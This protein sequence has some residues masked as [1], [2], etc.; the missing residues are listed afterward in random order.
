MD[1][2]ITAAKAYTATK[3]A[4]VTSTAASSNDSSSS[5][6]GDASTTATSSTAAAAGTATSQPSDELLYFD[7]D[8]PAAEVDKLR[9]FL[10]DITLH[11]CDIASVAVPHEV[12]VVW[13]DRIARE[14]HTQAK[15]EE[16]RGLVTA[17]FMRNL[18]V[19]VY[20]TYAHDHVCIE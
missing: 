19:S 7:M 8:K 11:A 9:Q 18:D 1:V 3:Q 5:S 13:G 17:E 6:S 2:Y 16:A 14:F 10:F 20:I 4:Q 15:T 12:A